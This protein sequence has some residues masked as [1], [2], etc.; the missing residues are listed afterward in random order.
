[1]TYIGILSCFI[2]LHGFVKF[3]YHQILYAPE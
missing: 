3:S 2:Y 1:M